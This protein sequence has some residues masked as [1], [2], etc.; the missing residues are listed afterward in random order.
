MNI[1]APAITEYPEYHRLYIGKVTE[2]DLMTALDNS[3]KDFEKFVRSMGPS[4]L[5]FR[6]AEGKWTI[7]EIVQHVSD[8]ERVFA[9][10]ALRFARND[11][12]ELPGFNENDYTAETNAGERTVD[13]LL[14]EYLAVRKA[15]VAL[16]NS[17][18]E[19]MLNRSGIASGKKISVRAIGFVIAGH[20][21][22]HQQVIKERYL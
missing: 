7:K 18:T 6:Y 12:T 10:R 19:K 4:K 21:I 14:E 11:K 3:A 1:S 8:T 17:L 9:Y 22:H 13:S 15:T 16:F 2:T 20:T 5:N